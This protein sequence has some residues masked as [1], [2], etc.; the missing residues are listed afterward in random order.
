MLGTFLL[1]LYLLPSV[2]SGQVT[3]PTLWIDD[4][5]DGNP[6]VRL[7]P[8]GSTFSTAT[9]LPG[10]LYISRPNTESFIANLVGVTVDPNFVQQLSVIWDELNHTATSDELA[11]GLG[12]VTGGG[13]VYQVTWFSDVGENGLGFNPMPS[14]PIENGQFQLGY[15]DSV[16]Q[17][18][19]RSDVEGVP[20]SGSSAALLLLALVPICGAM[21]FRRAR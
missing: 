11:V 17:V 10:G 15:S 6:V 1:A 21:Q 2:A 13:T 18:L 5:A 16:F 9:D 7:G 4:L 20:E 19:V 12:N 3:K 14:N 8:A